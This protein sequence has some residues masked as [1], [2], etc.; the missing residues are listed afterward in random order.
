MTRMSRSFLPS[1]PELARNQ[2]VVVEV[3][4]AIAESARELLEELLD[5]NERAR[6]ARFVFPDHR[7]R[8]VASHAALRLVLAH[9]LDEDPRALRFARGTHGKVKLAGRPAGDY[10][11]NLS[12][13]AERALIAVA[14][15]RDVGVDIEVHRS[16]LDVQALSRYVLSPAERRAFAAVP[17]GDRRAA[18]FRAWTR[19]ESFV[20]AIGEGLACPLDS[21]DISLDE[22]TDSAL[23][24]CRHMPAGAARWTTVPLEVGAGAAAALTARGPLSLQRRAPSVWT[25]A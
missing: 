24:E 25:F 21:F 17:T 23:L 4:L 1:L 20:K 10:E 14:R 11:I 18:F 9:Y 16:D 7:A 5:D 8:Y 15:S 3:R 22:H 19:K 2:V 13:S 6:A 12:H